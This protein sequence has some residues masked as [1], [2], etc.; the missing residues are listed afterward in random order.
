MSHGLPDWQVSAV[1]VITRAEWAA[2]N[3]TDILIQETALA[4]VPGNSVS[5]TY[6]PAADK[7]LYIVMLTGANYANLPLVDGDKPQHCWGYITVGGVGAI[8][9][10]GNGGIV[11]PLPK[12]VVVPGG[13][14][15]SI[16]LTNVSAHATDARV[17]AFGY[18]V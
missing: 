17:S 18:E 15:V 3:G 9:I 6:T 1:D 14:A 5:K 11:V 16:V 7:T 10:G 8:W 4:V 12:P 2:I 13:I